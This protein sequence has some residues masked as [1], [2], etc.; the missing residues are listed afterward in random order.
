MQ[1]VQE[2]KRNVSFLWHAANVVERS[3]AERDVPAQDG[4]DPFTRLEREKAERVSSNKK[5]AAKNRE[6]AAPSGAAAI[7]ATVKLSTKLDA[8]S[9]RGQIAKGKAIKKELKQASYFAGVSTASM[10]KFDT[11]LKGEKDNE[12]KL[13]GSRKKVLSVTGGDVEKNVAGNV[14]GKVI[15]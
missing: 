9:V 10:G 4:E 3:T 11:R 13:P 7:P 6:E 5:R 14:L 2:Y 8:A 1:K 12:R 15:R